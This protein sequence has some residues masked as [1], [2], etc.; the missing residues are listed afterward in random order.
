MLVNEIGTYFRILVDEPDK[1]W[2]TDAQV[3]ILMK[4]AYNQYY[5]VIT[6]IDEKPFTD[7]LTINAPGQ[8]TD[9]TVAPHN[10]L[11]NIGPYDGKGRLTRLQLVTVVNNGTF[12]QTFKAAKSSQELVNTNEYLYALLNKHLVFNLPISNAKIDLM[13][14]FIPD[15]DFSK[16]NIGDNEEV[17]EFDDFHDIIA[18]LMYKQY[19]IKDVSMN[20]LLENQLGQRIIDLKSY[21]SQGQDFSGSQYVTRV[22]RRN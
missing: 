8:S 17:D 6:D 22:Y 9:L 16:L 12:A 4:M 21:M 7:I 2:L 10:L 20:P 3:A 11:A 13:Y 1:T 15:I 14:T 18:L 19:A 5:R